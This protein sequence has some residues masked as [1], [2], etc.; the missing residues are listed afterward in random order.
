LASGQVRLGEDDVIAGLGLV[1]S[2]NQSGRNATGAVTLNVEVVSKRLEL[3]LRHCVIS[4]IAEPTGRVPD[5]S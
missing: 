3:D 5:Y 2:L 4:L 1:A